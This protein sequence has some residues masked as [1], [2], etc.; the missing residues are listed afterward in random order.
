MSVPRPSGSQASISRRQRSEWPRPF[1]GG[2]QRSTR[3]EKSISPTLSPLRAAEK[4]RSAP[5]IAAASVLERARLPN[6]PLA[7]TST[8]ST[9]V[10]SRSSTNCLT[11][12][13]PVR[14]VTFQ[15]MV[16]TSSPGTYSR[17]SANSI[18]RPLK[19]EW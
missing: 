12:G 3:S 10:S 16:R 17:T 2:I 5:S 11:C 9:T 13:R 1:A 6:V 4:A 19:E 14:A 18:P 8:A 7:L 15:S